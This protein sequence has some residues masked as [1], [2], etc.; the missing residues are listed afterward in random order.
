MDELIILGA[1]PLL[2]DVQ[3]ANLWQALKGPAPDGGL[4][5]GRKVAQYLSE[6]IDQPI[7]RQQG[8]EYLMQMRMRLRV[9]R[10]SHQELTQMNKRPGKKTSAGSVEN[11]VRAPRCRRRSLE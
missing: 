8:W 2:D 11:P 10:P 6:L 5:N 1:A 9:P 7:S 3:Q 4:W